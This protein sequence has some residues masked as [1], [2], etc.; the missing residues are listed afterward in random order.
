MSYSR[1]MT[2]SVAWHT[3]GSVHYPASETGGSVGY[4]ASGS[5]P[6]TIT[7]KVDT[8]PFDA[9]VAGCNAQVAALGTSVVAMNAAQCKAI[10]ESSAAVS[11]HIIGGF[12][13]LVRSELSQN[14]AAL[15]AKLNSGVM[16]VM[17]STKSLV[18]QRDI[19]KRDYERALARYSKVFN[20]LDEECRRRVEE[21]DKSAY[22]LSQT[23]KGQ[24][25]FDTQ[26]A[27]NAFVYANDGA[28]SN[29]LLFGAYIKSKTDII[30]ND[31]ARRVT[32]QASYMAQI[33]SLLRDEKALDKSEVFIPVLYTQCLS[34]EDK[35]QTDE[36][37]FTTETAKQWTTEG[38][39]EQKTASFAEQSGAKLASEV[40]A[41]RLSAMQGWKAMMP[42]EKDGIRKAFNT[43][44]EDYL[45][46]AS[47]GELS[48]SA[49]EPGIE[50]QAE[51]KRVYDVM[52]S[53]FNQETLTL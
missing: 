20:D 18:K 8:R 2:G 21:L 34:M 1:T 38:G 23:A 43:M 37:C 16:L 41:E 50:G 27:S 45:S 13:S 36:N 17:E 47:G 40:L 15:F 35:T 19:M 6:V 52:M 5:V 26:N 7:V 22:R 49:A 32:Q 10:E 11:K 51:Q 25:D 4:S 3:S 24:K 28:A 9:S 14:M 46:A 31:L 39:L 44:A 53:L 12:F 48:P 30:I 33:Q 29:S 42:E